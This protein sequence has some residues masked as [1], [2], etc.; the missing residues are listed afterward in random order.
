[1]VLGS[2]PAAVIL[3]Q[4]SGGQLLPVFFYGYVQAALKGNR[5][6][7]G[8]KI[9]NGHN[10][11]LFGFMFRFGVALYHAPNQVQGGCNVIGI[12]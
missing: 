8:E 10:V 12:G 5:C 1:M 9:G 6:D 3:Q 4:Y 7:M 2:I 11:L